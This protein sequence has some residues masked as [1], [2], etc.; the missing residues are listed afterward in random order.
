MPSLLFAG[1]AMVLVGICSINFS[2]L[3]NSTLQLESAPQ[4]RGRVM[5]FWSMAFLG[6]TTIGDPSSA[7]LAETAGARW[8]LHWA[9]W[10]PFPPLL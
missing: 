5:S 7:G 9:A 3:G 8:G 1:L 6:S 4:M 2:S 10:Q